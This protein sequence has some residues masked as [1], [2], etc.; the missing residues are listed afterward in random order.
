MKTAKE[1]SKIFTVCILSQAVL[2]SNSTPSDVTEKGSA[3]SSRSASSD[4][5]HQQ[6][7]LNEFELPKIK[8]ETDEFD[9]NLYLEL[10]QKAK[11][12]KEKWLKFVKE[13]P[14]DEKWLW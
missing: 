14:I 2:A 9:V 5:S 11:K 12:D 6:L 7:S 8:Q 4:T 10:L 1:L 3:N 13:N